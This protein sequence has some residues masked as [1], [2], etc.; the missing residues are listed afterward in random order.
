[1]DR[2]AP[3]TPQRKTKMV[4]AFPATL[5]RFAAVEAIMEIFEFPTER[6]RAAEAE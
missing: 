1:M 2:A 6:K 3:K 4:R 5:M